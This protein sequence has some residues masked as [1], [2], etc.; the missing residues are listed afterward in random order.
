MINKP[1]IRFCGAAI[2]I[3]L[4]TSRGFSRVSLYC[5]RRGSLLRGVSVEVLKPLPLCTMSIA[6]F[7]LTA[8][9]RGER[10]VG[11][12]RVFLVCRWHV[13]EAHCCAIKGGGGECAL[14]WCLWCVRVCSHPYGVLAQNKATTLACGAAAAARLCFYPILRSS[15]QSGV[16]NGGMWRWQGVSTQSCLVSVLVVWADG[17]KSGY[18]A[19]L[20]RVA[21]SPL[22]HEGAR[23]R[24]GDFVQP[25]KGERHEKSSCLRQREGL[26]KGTLTQG[27]IVLCWTCMV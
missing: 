12:C 27:K 4:P 13:S 11:V 2:L 8:S 21:R 3:L 16:G 23:P 18:R 24:G 17:R 25:R 15:R 5:E 9:A 14:R 22:L 20:W 6:F 1:K 26:V 19:E 10:C 7:F